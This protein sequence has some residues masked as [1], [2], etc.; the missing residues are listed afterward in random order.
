MPQKTATAVNVPGPQ[1]R[2]RWLSRV[3]R[4]HFNSELSH[5]ADQDVA[6][7]G[8]TVARTASHGLQHP[9]CVLVSPTQTSTDAAHC[10]G[11]ATRIAS[12]RQQDLVM[13]AFQNCISAPHIS[14]WAV[15]PINGAVHTCAACIFPCMYV[16][17]FHCWPL[18]HSSPEQKQPATLD[19]ESCP[20]TAKPCRGPM[21]G[22]W[23][24]DCWGYHH[25][26]PAS[27]HTILIDH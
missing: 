15:W 20:A 14:P 8:H 17:A 11:G 13:L 16:H 19:S 9:A 7:S 18:I 24:Q 1:L 23:L 5:M 12:T 10:A 2:A 21:H 3:Q 27:I 22:V 4:I 25:T 26:R 6:T